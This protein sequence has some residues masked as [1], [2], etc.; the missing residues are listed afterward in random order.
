MHR[1]HAGILAKFFLYEEKGDNLQ[2]YFWKTILL[3]ELQ[4]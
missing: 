2:Y 4:Y 3:E 1:A